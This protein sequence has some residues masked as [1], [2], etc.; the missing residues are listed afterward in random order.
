MDKVAGKIVKILYEIE[1]RTAEYDDHLHKIDPS[2][3]AK[4]K[5]CAFLKDSASKIEYAA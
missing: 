1:L 5:Y 4:Q 3:D 2:D